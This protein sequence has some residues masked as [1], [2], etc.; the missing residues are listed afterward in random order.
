MDRPPEKYLAVLKKY[1]GFNEFRPMQ[2]KIIN[3]VLNE[4][5]DN[6][7]VMATGY[8]KSL[9]YQFPPVFSQGVAIVVSPLISLMQD[10][11]LAL[12]VKNIPAALMGTAQK[13]KSTAMSEMKAGK[14]R[15]VYVTPEWC[16]SDGAVQLLQEM[17]SGQT[18]K[19]TLVAIDEAHCVSQWGMDFRKSYRRLGDL[20]L[21]L[22]GV[23]FM[24]LTATATP[25]VQTDICDSLHLSRPR[26]SCTSFDRPNLYLSCSIKGSSIISDVK[27]LFDSQNSI[28]PGIDKGSCIV[29]CPTK[30]KVD[31]VATCLAGNGYKCEMYHA[32]LS[33]SV[34][35]R[36]HKDFVRDKVQIVVATVAFGMGIDKPDVRCII[37]YGAPIDIETY[38]Q[39]I[40][41]AG[42]DG[43][44]SHCHVF[45]QQSDFGLSKHF[46]STLDSQY[47]NYKERMTR[48]M[49]R[50]LQT[51]DC[52][53]KIIVTHFDPSATVED[54]DNCCDNCKKNGQKSAQSAPEYDLTEDALLLLKAVKLLGGFY[55]LQVP[56]LLVRGSSNKKLPSKYCDSELFS[57]GYDKPEE[58]WKLLGG[59]LLR[60]FL[61]ED[62]FVN[63]NG[64]FGQFPI[65]TVNVSRSGTDFINNSSF[66]KM[67]VLQPTPEM[68]PHLIKFSRSRAVRPGE[69]IGAAGNVNDGVDGVHHITIEEVL[70]ES[71]IKFRS[72]VAA[73]LDCM[74]YMILSNHTLHLLTKNPPQNLAEL[75]K[76]D[77]VTEAKIEKFGD[78]C[79]KCLEAAKKNYEH[80][81]KNPRPPISN[82][83]QFSKAKKII[84]YESDDSSG[85]GEKEE[86]PAASC[87]EPSDN[88]LQDSF[89]DDDIFADLAD[90]KEL[91]TQA[92][93]APP[94]P[95]SPTDGPPM[96]KS[97]NG[98]ILVEGRQS[99]PV[100]SQSSEDLVKRNEL[101][102][103]AI[104][105]KFKL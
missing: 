77:G 13:D 103:K 27:S 94:E 35:E 46:L 84:K 66:R 59:L 68:L 81:S 14:Y 91:M 73:E 17:A 53:R 79:L 47:R 9:C 31:E 29:Y 6:C 19:L 65:K 101:K 30:K 58:Y 72:Q 80:M 50:Y 18:A 52:R 26:M 57:K 16:T 92:Q 41:R 64:S 7:V 1:F 85:E 88:W 102:K 51:S 8:G 83:K 97:K 60:E 36:V 5:K 105:K 23:P 62:K 37:H 55:G 61:L 56:I 76:V 71:L 4:K 95:I 96:K 93:A 100:S 12:K 22:P 10:Q 45:Y 104:A 21:S 99:S 98:S 25:T 48:V 49:E 75:S 67:C 86:I 42:R 28:L 34:R 74:P 38:Y 78:A 15:L 2:W 40:G 90:D 24:A 54:N 39:E 43:L 89:Q 32:D 20:K 87:A 33:L 3:S 82:A 11:V 44:Q 69:W 70:F 63:R